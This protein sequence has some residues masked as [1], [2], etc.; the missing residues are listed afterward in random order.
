MEQTLSCYHSRPRR[1][2]DR[3]LDYDRRF[4]LV[5]EQFAPF[6]NHFQDCLKTNSLI[7]LQNLHLPNLMGYLQDRSAEFL[8]AA[9]FDSLRRTLRCLQFRMYATCS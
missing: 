1:I 6:R 4:D 3:Q 2:H 7:A 9:D 5:A 8:L